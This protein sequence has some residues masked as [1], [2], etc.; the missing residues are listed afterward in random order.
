MVVV[1]VPI[2]VTVKVI[3]QVGPLMQKDA[4]LMDLTSL[5]AEPVA[6]MLRSSVAEVIGLHPLFGPAVDTLAGHTHRDLPCA[7]RPLARVGK[8]HFCQAG[9]DPYRNDSGET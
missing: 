5:K 8:R 2:E 7:G 1:S 6:A 4:L 3:E 9:G